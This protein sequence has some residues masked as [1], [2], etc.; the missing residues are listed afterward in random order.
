MPGRVIRRGVTALRLLPLLV[1]YVAVCAV[2]QPG[3]EP[4]RD[5][6][7]LLG[8]VRD[9]LL[10][11]AY[12]DPGAV[13]DRANFLW[14]GHG[15]PLV[16]TPLVALGLPLGALRF[17]G[18]LLLWGALLAFHALMRP[19]LQARRALVATYAL[20]L[21]GPFATVLVAVHKEPLAILATVLA[22]LGL[23]RGLADEGR[24]WHLAGA[25]VALGALTMVRLEYGWVLM[26]VLGTALV[27]WVARRTSPVPRRLAAVCALALVLCL[28]WLV[29]TYAITGQV[30]YW[31]TSGGLSLYWMSP[32]TPEATGTWHRP[33]AV[34]G[35][36]DLR[37]HRALFASLP[38]APVARDLALREAAVAKIRADPLTYARNLAA[39]TSRLFFLWP[40]EPPRRAP[41]VAGAVVFNGALLL[42]VA[43]AGPRL[44]RRRGAL[45]PETLP[46]ALFAA[47][48]VA[49]HLPP[50]A[51][52]RMLL[53]LV[54][55]VAWLVTLAA[56]PSR[57]GLP[58]SPRA[59]SRSRTAALDPA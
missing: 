20:G 15:L 3:P 40:M 18:P 1:L 38:T 32:S 5:E 35:E 11:G 43:W 45:P 50:S 56:E 52:P 30:A 22:L 19:R 36:P 16:L 21:Y 37:P 39:N 25:G 6:A 31:G 8:Y 57:P 47:L 59:P 54:P 51:Q 42:G 13:D 10:A 4:V 26:A 33:E 9:Y 44:W 41:V 7:F 58:A 34:A 24:W 27:W 49:V 29:H 46:F 28:P 53:P 12:L 2:G 23:A 17:T 14:H 55:V 48:G